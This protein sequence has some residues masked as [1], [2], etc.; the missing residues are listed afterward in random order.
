[1]VEEGHVVRDFY[2]GHTHVKICDDY[3]RNQTPEEAAAILERIK[4]IYI[5]AYNRGAT[6]NREK[7]V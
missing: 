1:M 5:T 4:Q 6:K 2:I 7:N 3:C